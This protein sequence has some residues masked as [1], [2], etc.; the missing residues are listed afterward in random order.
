MKLEEKI[1]QI[2]RYGTVLLGTIQGYGL[3]VGLESQQI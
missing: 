1:T 2:T 3:A